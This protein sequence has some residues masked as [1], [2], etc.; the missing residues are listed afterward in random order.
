[1]QIK[2]GILA[3]AYLLYFFFIVLSLAVIG[4][5]FRIQIIEGEHWKEVAREQTLV[6]MNIEAVRGSIFADNG[7]LLATDLPF[8][9][10]RMDVN[11]EALTDEIFYGN[12]DSLALRLSQLFNDKSTR[13]YRIELVRARKNKERFHL[14]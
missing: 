13:E 7:S 2:K 14:I 5:V 4:Q 11:A 12:V 9:Q 8:Y 3:R 1:M 10:V 6:P